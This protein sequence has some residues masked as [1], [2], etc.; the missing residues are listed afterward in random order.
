MSAA[1]QQR[2]VFP[3]DLGAEV[4]LLPGGGSPAIVVRGIPYQEEVSEKAGAGKSRVRSVYDQVLVPKSALPPGLL[5]G[6]GFD[7]FRV[8]YDGRTFKLYRVEELLDPRRVG[9]E[10]VMLILEPATDG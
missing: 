7:G 1:T 8:E 2:E 6:Q 4:R 3:L 10:A 5:R 9:A